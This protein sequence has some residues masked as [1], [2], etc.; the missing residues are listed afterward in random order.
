[1]GSNQRCKSFGKSYTVPPNKL[2]R[3]NH[4]SLAGRSSKRPHSWL[5][6]GVRHLYLACQCKYCWWGRTIL[7]G[8]I[9][10]NPQWSPQ[11]IPKLLTMSGWTCTKFCEIAS[12]TYTKFVWNLICF[13]NV[14]CTVYCPYNITGSVI[15][16]SYVFMWIVLKFASAAQNN[17]SRV[18]YWAGVCWTPNTHTFRTRTRTSTDFPNRTN[19]LRTPDRALDIPIH[20]NT[21]LSIVLPSYSVYFIPIYLVPRFM[22]KSLLVTWFPSFISIF[23]PFHLIFSPLSFF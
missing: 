18:L 22:T 10:S 6:I 12:Q 13:T 19:A 3:R 11:P 23:L 4:Q 5:Y 2:N 15:S 7:F 17:N 14:Y 20:P 1:M 16:A 9:P 8:Q 21:S